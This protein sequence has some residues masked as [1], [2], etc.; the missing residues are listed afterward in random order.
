M[1]LPPLKSSGSPIKRFFSVLKGLLS[2][3]VLLPLLVGINVLQMMSFVLI[4]PLSD[5]LFR[6]FN[7]GCAAFWW[8][9]SYKWAG[10]YGT[11]IVVSGDELPPEENAMLVANH[12]EAP[13]IPMLFP[14]AYRAGRIGDLKWFVKNILKYVPGVGWGMVFLDCIFV[15]RNWTS[16]KDYISSIFERI[17]TKKIPVW[18][19]SFVEGTRI[20]PKKLE[21]SNEYAEKAGL[22]PTRHVLLPRTKGFSATVNALRPHLDAVYDI[23]IGYVDGVPSA[24]QWF[25][26]DVKKAYLHVKRYPLETLPTDEEELS[27]WLLDRFYEKDE[28]LETFYETGEMS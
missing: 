5:D 20:R 15:K 22:T 11:E 17:I 10:W 12:Q 9:L 6:R 7:R 21:R 26:G 19:I 14:I 3:G 13:D 24:A 4:K 27:Q 23:T 1:P 2:A 28:R 8:G 18:I 25:Q 16:D